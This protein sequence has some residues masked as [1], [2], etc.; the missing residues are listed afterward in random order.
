[1]ISVGRAQ[2]SRGQEFTVA[3]VPV[4]CRFGVDGLTLPPKRMMPGQLIQRS[5]DVWLV[6]AALGRDATGTRRYHNH[7][8]HGS[9]R[10]AQRYLTKILRELDTGLFVEPTSQRLE[11]FIGQWLENSVRLRVREKTLTDYTSLARLHIFPSLGT[12]KLSQLVA[13]EIQA[14]YSTLLA[15]GLS[16]RTVRYVHSVLHGA[17]EQ[18]VRWRLL[19]HNPAKL[20]S[21]PRNERRE[22]RALSAAEAA[23][24]LDAA[25]H[26][27]W[28]ALWLLLL[29][30]G[31]RP[32]EALGLRWSDLEGDRLRIQRALVRS[33]SGWSLVEP[34]TQRARRSV[35]LPNGLERAIVTHRARQAEDRLR[36]GGKWIDSGLIFSNREGQ[37]LD[38]REVVRR[39]FH[40]I[41]T[42]AALPKLRPYDLRH[43]CATLLLGAGEHVKVVSER[44]GHASA[45]LTLDVYSHVLPDMQ[46]RAAEKMDLILFAPRAG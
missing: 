28:Y 23:R 19:A 36:A 4:V 40:R 13:P 3:C 8:V 25:I 24:F 6:R 12:R 35:T 14:L 26:D 18:A 45:A 11:A 1:M 31:L 30:T 39:H 17:L 33:K 5:K 7:T 27:R 34:K 22:M 32:G 21:L 43:S 20:V 29:A 46:Q 37:P 10:D 16:P 9:R 44:L 2:L 41:L 38:Y 42:A 15:E